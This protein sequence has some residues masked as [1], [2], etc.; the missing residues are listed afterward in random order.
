MCVQTGCMLTSRGFGSLVLQQRKLES[1][2][3]PAWLPSQCVPPLR[4][5]GAAAGY[6]KILRLYDVER[7]DAAPAEIRGAPDK[8]R[9]AGAWSIV[10]K[11]ARFGLEVD[12]WLAQRCEK[13][14]TVP[15]A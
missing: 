4:V 12:G 2:R 5:G 11:P 6:E 7:P 10:A 14:C 9:E 15:A 8:V 3:Q 13:D 1:A